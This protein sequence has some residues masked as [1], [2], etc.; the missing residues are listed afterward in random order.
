MQYNVGLDF[1][2][3]NSALAIAASDGTVQ[4][5]EFQDRPNFRSI[6]HFLCLE[7][8]ALQQALRTG[9]SPASVAG[10]W[11]AVERYASHLGEGRLIQSIKSFL[12]SRTFTGTTIC[13]KSY[14]L[15]DLIEELLGVMLDDAQ[16]QVGHLG[17]RIV[18][19]RPV[20]FVG[21]DASKRPGQE[22]EN[23]ESALSYVESAGNRA[24]RRLRTA[25]WRLGFDDITFV[26]EPIG[27]AYH[28]ART[29]RQPST[30]LVADFGGGTSD[31]T[32]LRVI[33]G[34]DFT[35]LATDGIA[36][37]GDTFDAR[38]VRRLVSPTL[39][40][41]KRILP[42]ESSSVQSK[43]KRTFLTKAATRF[44]IA[45]DEELLEVLVAAFPLDF[46]ILGSTVQKLAAMRKPEH[47]SDIMT[48]RLLRPNQQQAGLS[49]VYRLGYDHIWENGAEILD[50]L[51][52]GECVV[53]LLNPDRAA[54]HTVENGHRLPSVRALIRWAK[55]EA[56]D[57][58]DT[59][60][61]A[62]LP[63]PKWI[64][65]RLESW[66]ELLLLN[67]PKVLALLARL[68]AQGDDS[69]RTGIRTLRNLI[70]Q[71]R[72]FDMYQAVSRAKQE[73]SVNEK[74][75]LYFQCPPKE[76]RKVL[77]RKQFEAWIARDIK[78]IEAC[79]GRLLVASGCNTS[80]I[81]LVFMT[82]GT[83]FVPAVRAIFE[84][85]FGMSKLRYGDEFVSVAKGLALYARDS[86]PALDPTKIN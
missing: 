56:P 73:L 75:E 85:R 28:Y 38:V 54:S 25:L 3:T 81:D 50:V 12:T 62:T 82:G 60:E 9:Q 7:G 57:L 49:N 55:R 27:A 8:E 24:E 64:Y 10:G 53:R 17:S 52:D 39:G 58:L 29:I 72:G 19:G 65:S 22:P 79:V 66:H 13:G 74:S 20:R 26:Y 16:A 76:I 35:V 18:V 32:V 61:G 71:E 51:K 1:G 69:V 4:T 23:E 78:K 6:L 43:V 40:R 21:E 34:I 15:E 33:P 14:L 41:D 42:W 5:I 30:I 70:Q 45:F 59:I 47:K 48:V 44:D 63:M 77:T 68:E 36:I 83:S 37:G 80:D 46:A 84:H 2:T 31:F 67:D 86:T 11:R